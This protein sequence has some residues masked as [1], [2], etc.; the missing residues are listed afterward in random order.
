MTFKPQT[1]GYSALKNK[2]KKEPKTEQLFIPF[3]F[4]PPPQFIAIKV[5]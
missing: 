2:Q 5:T 1:D 4:F 3:P